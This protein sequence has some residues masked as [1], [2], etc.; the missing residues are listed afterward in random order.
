MTTHLH[1]HN[2]SHD[3]ISIYCLKNVSIASIALNGSYFMNYSTLDR[4]GFPSK[5]FSTFD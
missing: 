3:A 4:S 2:L 1:L 5:K